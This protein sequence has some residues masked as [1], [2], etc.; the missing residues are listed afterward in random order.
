MKKLMFVSAFLFGLTG[1][2]GMGTHDGSAAEKSK[3]G[4]AAQGKILIAYFSH[5]GN[6]REI[7][8]QIHSLVG[9]DVFEIR[10]VQTYPNEYNAVVD[11]AKKEQQANLRPALAAN[12][13]N[14]DSY[15]VVFVGFPNWWGTMPMP[16]FTFLEGHNLK[17]KTV[18]PFCTHEGSRMGRSVGD[19]RKLCPQ[20][21]VRD[22][23]AVRGHDVKNA[24]DDVAQWLRGMG[25]LK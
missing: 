1:V 10:S 5:S 15:S 18:I 3:A 16:V 4:G 21:T 25:L 2:I 11:Q 19:I 9:G 12:V 6:T 24:R 20:S 23:L 22:G 14:I 7:A 17:G 8:N 13:P